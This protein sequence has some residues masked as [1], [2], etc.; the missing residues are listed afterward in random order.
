MFSANWILPHWVVHSTCIKPI[1]MLSIVVFYAFYVYDNQLCNQSCLITLPGFIDYLGCFIILHPVCV[2][3]TTKARPWTTSWQ[4]FQDSVKYLLGIANTN[5]GFMIWTPSQVAL[6]QG[7]LF[8]NRQ[9]HYPPHWEQCDYYETDLWDPRWCVKSVCEL[10][11]MGLVFIVWRVNHYTIA[12]VSLKTKSFCHLLCFW[13]QLVVIWAD[14]TNFMRFE[15]A[16]ILLSILTC[17]V[18]WL[19]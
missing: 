17:T 11:L 16:R 10:N 4:G 19:R 3:A 2:V 14:F 5:C 8:V 7:H 13:I 6:F 15:L 1:F 9:P 18:S 12:G